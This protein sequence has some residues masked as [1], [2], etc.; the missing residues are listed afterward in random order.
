MSAASS[1]SSESIPAC[2]ASPLRPGAREREV[3]LG[4]VHARPG[5]D[6]HLEV[7]VLGV[8]LQRPLVRGDRGQGVRERERVAERRAHVV[9]HLVRAVQRE[10]LAGALRQLGDQP[11]LVQ[12]AAGQQ[13]DLVGDPVV[14]LVAVPGELVEPQARVLEQ[15][16]R[17]R[18][19]RAVAVV[20]VVGADQVHLAVP[21]SGRLLRP[22]RRGERG[23]LGGLEPRVGGQRARRGLLDR[24]RAGAGGDEHRGREQRCQPFHACLLAGSCRRPGESV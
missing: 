19:Q 13:R 22:L 18:H 10:V 17:D 4:A 20:V 9:A 11:P 5:A 3:D 24:E 2:T 14:Q 12:A 7:R 21:A 6:L 1:A 8:V 23:Q 16:D 15:V